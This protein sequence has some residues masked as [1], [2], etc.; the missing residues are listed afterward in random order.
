MSE[1]FLDL[2][3]DFA[4]WAKK[5]AAKGL[6]ML[7]LHSIV[8]GK[9]TCGRDNCG[10]NA[11]KHP[12]WANWPK[13]ATPDF[14][15]A[16]KWFA[17]PKAPRN[18]GLATGHGVVVL[19]VD[20]D[21]GRESLEQLLTEH[22]DQWPTGP[23][24]QSGSGGLHF[25][26]RTPEVFSN[27]VGEIMPGLDVR[28]LGGQI[29][30]CPSVH[31]SGKRYA[32]LGASFDLEIPTL[33]EWLADLMRG[34]SA[35]QFN[36]GE[37]LAKQPPA[38]SGEGGSKVLMRVTGQLVKQGKI[39]SVEQYLTTIAPWNK[40]CEPS[41]SEKELRHAFDSAYGR[42]QTEAT[43]DLPL[44]AKGE[45]VCDRVAVDK[46]IT[47]DARYEWAF[48]RDLLSR[49][50]LY[51]GQPVT[52]NVVTSIEV[53]ICERYRLRQINRSWLE[54]SIDHAAERHAFH[55]VADYLAG[56]RWDGIRR[57]ASLVTEVLGAP[58][59]PIFARYLERWSIGAAR[60]A[61]EPGCKVD[62]AL[63]LQGP[64][65]IK[66]STF[67]RTLFGAQWFRDS[68]IDL[69]NKDSFLQIQ[70]WGYEWSE[71]ENITDKKTVSQVKA[72]L[73]SQVDTYR[74]PFAR[75]AEAV[76]RSCVVVGTTNK[77]E[78]LTDPT[79]SRRFWIVPCSG[80]IDLERVARERDQL[81][82][83][84]VAM[85]QA[86]E[87]H[88]LQPDEC[89]AMEIASEPYQADDPV[90]DLALGILEG[91]P[92]EIGW[93]QLCERLLIRHDCGGLIRASIIR[94]LKHEGFISQRVQERGTRRTLWIRLVPPSK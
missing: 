8:D 94:A 26:F 51:D 85:A 55:P 89:R 22:P 88:W 82:A 31:K 73:S 44:N 1:V 65:G 41:W 56:L 16:R 80:M 81:W 68:P 15:E 34:S 10:R 46:I 4:F 91:I 40:R 77:T 60:R 23:V 71:L 17:D 58:S 75:R 11:G 5:Y 38:V 76:P 39:R 54:H 37:W 7:P 70:T 13:R 86:G 35:G 63:I 2:T 87:S 18:I 9:C 49:D 42:F 53:E 48:K 45:V 83:E 72:F 21:I 30:A 33:P 67:F 57:W 32:W 69:S 24:Q 52:D 79:G 19:D 3:T 84:A 61:L 14:E 27:R 47:K 6:H 78:I 62:T 59:A 28:S 50:T 12:V 74:A 43:I 90:Y 20:G 29:V 64:Q 36:V 93:Q 92:T 25:L 66:K